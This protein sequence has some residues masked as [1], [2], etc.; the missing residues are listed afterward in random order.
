MTTDYRA[1][2]AE[3]VDAYVR[4][5]NLAESIS[6]ARALL[7]QPEPQPPADDEAAVAVALI[8]LRS[9]VMGLDQMKMY[10]AAQ[11]VKRAADLLEANAQ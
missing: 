4:G 3:L 8:E 9:T 11:R 5:N 2:C 10:V 7:D 6:R 1:M